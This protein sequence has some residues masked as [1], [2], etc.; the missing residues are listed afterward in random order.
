MRI[1]TCFISSLLVAGCSGTDLPLLDQGA[2]DL[3]VPSDLAVPGDLAVTVDGAVTDGMSQ[4]CGDPDAGVWSELRCTGL[5]SDWA[6]RTIDP[7][8]KLFVPTYKL[9]SDGASKRRWIYLPPGTQI[10]VSDMNGWT[11]PVGTKLWKEFS[12]NLG[13]DGGGVDTIIETRL[14]W[15]RASGWTMTTYAWSPDQ[16]TALELP[17][18][19]VDV[20]NTNHYEIPSADNGQC[21]TCHGGRPDR[22]LGFEAISLAEATPLG[23]SDLQA[24]SLLTSTNGNHN[25]AASALIVPGNATEK[26][27]LGYL[28]ANC[29]NACHHPGGQGPFSM[30]VDIVA[31]AAPA[32]VQ[33]TPAFG[34]A[35]NVASGFR[36]SGGTGNYYRIRPTDVTRSTIP[37]RM[38]TR[39]GYPQ[40]PPVDT[41]VVDTAGLGL[42]TAW[43][44]A[45]TA[46]PY[47]APSPP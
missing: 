33:S 40:M 13:A 24:A 41:H 9:W 3:A 46:A 30:R 1:L 19:M 18:G 7:A 43:I 11:F 35:I 37:F 20:P 25:L 8:N 12:L 22:V 42:V 36:P 5:Y 28:H 44:N 32:N 31:G 16:L 23:W 14:L 47:P 4:A 10:D 29:G 34:G 27:A 45:M 6:S 15:K 39:G 21:N 17:G 26:P 2:P 38:N